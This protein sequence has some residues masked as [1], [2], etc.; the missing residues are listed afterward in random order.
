[1]FVLYSA[2]LLI[3]GFRLSV[4]LTAQVLDR[5]ENALIACNMR[6]HTPV[7]VAKSHLHQSAGISCAA[8]APVGDVVFA[9][10]QIGSGVRRT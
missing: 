3:A 9:K 10:L 8:V 7:L 2:C 1:M 5:G 4:F 6:W